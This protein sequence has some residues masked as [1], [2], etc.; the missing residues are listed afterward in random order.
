MRS[1]L[2]LLTPLLLLAGCVNESA[3]YLIDGSDHAVSEFEHYVDE[4]LA[5]CLA[6][7]VDDAKGG[8]G[9]EPAR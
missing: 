3:S 4:V 5:F 2:V 8:A 1:T 9:S 7:P 6:A